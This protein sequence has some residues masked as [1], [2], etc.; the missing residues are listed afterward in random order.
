MNPDADLYENVKANP[1]PN[2]VTMTLS[3]MMLNP[4]EDHRL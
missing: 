4:E 3:S 1:M 2:L